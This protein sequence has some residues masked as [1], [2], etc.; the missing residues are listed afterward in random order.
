MYKYFTR[1][2]GK[3]LWRLHFSLTFFIFKCFFVYYCLEISN[4]KNPE[5]TE[6]SI[7]CDLLKI[8]GMKCE[9]SK[10]FM[11]YEMCGTILSHIAGGLNLIEEKNVEGKKR[12][13]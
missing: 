4:E 13:L 8:A 6:R 12:L 9:E 3:F 1:S 2:H 5:I 10:N 11:L 7:E